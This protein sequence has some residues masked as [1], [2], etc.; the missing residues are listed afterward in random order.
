MIQIAYALSDKNGTYSKFAGASISSIL[1]NT[2]ENVTF[3]LLHDGTIS[4]ENR[5]RFTEMVKD[6]GS[7]IYFYDVPARL[8]KTLEQGREI[9]PEGLDSERY[10]GVNM[11]RLLL[12]EVLSPELDKVIFLDA[13][14]IVN[15][16]INELWQTELG[17]A[18]LAAVSDYDVL[19]HFGQESKIKPNSS[20]LYREKFTDVH[21]IFNAGVML[22]NLKILRHR[23]SLLLEG[24]KFLREHDGQW[25]FYDNDILIGFFANAYK[26]LPWRFHLRLGWA[27]TYGGNELERAIYP[28]VDRDYSFNPAN[29]LHALFL[30]YLSQSPWGEGAIRNSFYA[31]KSVSLQRVQDRMARIRL[32]NNA[33]RMKKRVFMGLKVDEERLRA[34]FGLGADEVFQPLEPG[35]K[36]CLPCSIETH[37]YL[38]FWSNY[39]EVRGILECAGLKEYVHFADGTLLMPERAED[40]FLDDRSVI[41]GM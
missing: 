26:H 19:A 39:R 40:M 22:L 24:L 4:E 1:A 41:W 18:P 3:H 10:T 38:V 34:D 8:G 9:L 37:F 33:S 5:H 27:R 7:G 25:D 17:D 2:G 29:S 36:V 35:R 15:L 6:S 13:D 12:Q 11:Y 20:F 23:E 16:D 30:H 32:I 28:Y 31:A 21:G 14:T